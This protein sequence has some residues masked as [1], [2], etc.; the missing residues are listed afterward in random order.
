M[1]GIDI[2]G[3]LAFDIGL[4][5]MVK[6]SKR[7]IGF[8]KE[9]GLM[10]A[11]KAMFAEVR[12]ADAEFLT[13]VLIP[14]ARVKKL[15]VFEERLPEFRDRLATWPADDY[16]FISRVAWDRVAAALG[17]AKESPAWRVAG[18]RRTLAKLEVGIDRWIID[19]AAAGEA[20]RKLMESL[21]AFV[22]PVDPRGGPEAFRAFRAEAAPL[23]ESLT[24]AGRHMNALR[25]VG[26]AI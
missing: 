20:D 7:I 4:E 17:R 21:V 2:S 6:H 1:P 15:P 19:G 13:G 24:L 10:A 25:V 9:R 18:V 22:T 23:E 16:R 26:S 14:L 11:L 12:K 3:V 8:T 5:G